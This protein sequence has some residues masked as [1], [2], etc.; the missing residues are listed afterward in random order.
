[1]RGEKITWTRWKALALVELVLVMIAL[2]LPV[3]PS[4]TG[5][6]GIPLPD[7]LGAYVQDVLLSFVLGHVVLVV[8]AVVAWG[9]WL[10]QGRPSFVDA[11]PEDRIETD[12]RSGPS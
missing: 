12:T 7:T 11:N 3:T 5:P 6:P 2:V 8:F 1:M 10:V 9:Y 4:K